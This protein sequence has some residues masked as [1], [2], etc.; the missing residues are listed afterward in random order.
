MKQKLTVSASPR[1]RE[2]RIEMDFEGGIISR[3]S[4]DWALIAAGNGGDYNAMTASWGA[5]G[6]LWEKPIAIC[7]VRPQRFT[8]SFTDTNA[9]FSLTFFG[10]DLRAKTHKVFGGES[11]RDTDKAQKAGITPIVFEEGAIGFEE[12]IE[13]IVCRKIY[14]DDFNSANFLDPAIEKLYPQNDYH[15]FYIGEIVKFYKKRG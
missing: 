4:K 3:I 13:T 11:G 10:R 2:A 15:R 5:L 8:R 12:A 9:L 7:F 14:F 1:W 6:Y